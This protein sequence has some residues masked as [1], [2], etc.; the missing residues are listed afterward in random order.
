MA[1][2]SV[3]KPKFPITFTPGGDRTNEAILK[4]INEI[5]R[6]YDLMRVM[7]SE[8]PDFDELFA[9]PAPIA[10]FWVADEAKPKKIRPATDEQVILYLFERTAAADEPVLIGFDPNTKKIFG[11]PVSQVGVQP[12]SE[13]AAYIGAAYIGASYITDEQD[14][15]VIPVEG[16]TLSMTEAELNP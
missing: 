9:E 10:V 2:D 12:P 6:L 5:K 11:V 16:V 14:A 7:N 3:F 13:D 8:M 4:H 15:P 1:D